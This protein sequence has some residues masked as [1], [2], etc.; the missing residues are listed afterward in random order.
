VLVVDTSAIVAA[1]VES[2]P[3]DDLFDVLVADGD[4]HAPHLIDVELLHVLRR[5][6]ARGELAHDRATDARTDFSDLVIARYPHA[7]LADR[8]WELR[9]NLT[10][11]DAAFVALSEEL[12]APLV[13]CDA[14]LAAA[15]GHRARV[16]LFRAPT[17]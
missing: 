10:A 16:V 5:L 3:A 9:D 1:L 11:Y 8:I 13:T 7:P 15:P 14:R 12:G 6:V 4:L 17:R 2:P